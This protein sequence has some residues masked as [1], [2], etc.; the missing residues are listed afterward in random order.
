MYLIDF[1]YIRSNT[2]VFFDMAFG[3][4]IKTNYQEPKFLKLICELLEKV[5]NF[6]VFRFLFLFIGFRGSFNYSIPMLY[7]FFRFVQFQNPADY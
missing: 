4:K 6:D 5:D 7:T 3:I 1:L 2:V